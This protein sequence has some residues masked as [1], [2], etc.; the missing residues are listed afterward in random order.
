MRYHYVTQCTQNV[1]VRSI[2]PR[3]QV[4]EQIRSDHH[5][6]HPS[7]RLIFTYGVP[8]KTTCLCA[9]GTRHRR[10]RRRQ[11]GAVQE[12]QTIITDQGD[13]LV[14]KIPLVSYV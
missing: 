14:L 11:P 7:Y 9:R 5:I 12:S 6:C 13:R 10:H 3:Y 4:D 2:P 8:E 1:L